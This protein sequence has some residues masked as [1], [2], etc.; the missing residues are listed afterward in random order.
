MLLMTFATRKEFEMVKA[1]VWLDCQQVM[2]LEVEA[3][4]AG[5]FFYGVLALPCQAFSP[6]WQR[7][8]TALI[9]INESLIKVLRALAPL[10]G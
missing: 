9:N 3:S 7:S 5:I 8:D 6:A 2:Q 4:P 10:P 1:R